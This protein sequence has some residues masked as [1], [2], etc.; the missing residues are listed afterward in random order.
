MSQGGHR[1]AYPPLDEHWA[2]RRE[3]AAALRAMSDLMVTREID[4][5]DAEALAHALAP[6][7]EKA[8]SAP[9]LLG[10]QAW[11]DAQSYDNFGIM[12]VELCPLMGAS[13]P[14]SI[15]MQF[16]LEEGRA[17]ATCQAG[18]AFEGPPERLHGGFVAA[19]FDQFLGMAQMAWGKVGMTRSLHV[20]YH[21]ATPLNTELLLEAQLLEARDRH[22]RIKASLS[23]NGQ[24][25]ATCSA[26]FLIPK[27][28]FDTGF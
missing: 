8:K 4:P 20:E 19:V 16:T 13:N 6:W 17:T 28:G 18:W 23:A 26:D 1:D 5:N 22:K 25:T 24:L 7:I 15:P 27:A 3:A 10:K 11:A 9:A 21:S 14:R 12:S 2:R